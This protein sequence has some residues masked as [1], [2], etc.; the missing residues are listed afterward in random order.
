MAH[1]PSNVWKLLVLGLGFGVG[2]WGL[3]SEAQGLRLRV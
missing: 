2:F 1:M 3:G